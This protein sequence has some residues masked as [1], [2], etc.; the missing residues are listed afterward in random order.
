[1]SKSKYKKY[2]G[3]KFETTPIAQAGELI[4]VTGLTHTMAGQIIGHEVKRE[5]VLLQPVMRVSVLYPQSLNAKDVLAIFKKL[6]HI[7][8]LIII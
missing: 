6:A 7:L 3:K 1:M 4:G 2:Q 8:Q 5:E